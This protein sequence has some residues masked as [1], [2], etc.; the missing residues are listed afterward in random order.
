MNALTKVILLLALAA[1]IGCADDPNKN[2]KPVDPN[3]KI[4]GEPVSQ[5]AA[6]P[7]KKAAPAMQGSKEAAPKII[8]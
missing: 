2:L 6:P 8:N 3:T 5:G 4:Q 1:F 7:G